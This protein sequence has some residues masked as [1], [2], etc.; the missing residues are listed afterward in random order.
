[1]KMVEIFTDASF[2]EEGLST[3]YFY[4]MI[5]GEQIVNKR[6]FKGS[7]VS[8]VKAEIE[9]VT[10]ALQRADKRG[11]FGVKVYTDCKPIVHAVYESDNEHHDYKYIRHLL[12]QTEGELIWLPR[13]T[14]EIRIADAKC[15]ELMQTQLRRKIVLN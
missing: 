2:M 1:M 5:D 9:T 12:K 13:E 15:K 8:S 4:V 11:W 6:N 7:E 3:H 10:R 14:K